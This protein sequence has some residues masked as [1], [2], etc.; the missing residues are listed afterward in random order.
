MWAFFFDIVGLN[1]PLVFC[2]SN[3]LN[4]NIDFYKMNACVYK[5]NIRT[6]TFLSKQVILNR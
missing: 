3:S 5:I 2:W 6:P 4:I 1:K